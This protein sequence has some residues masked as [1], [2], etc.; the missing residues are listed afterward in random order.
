MLCFSASVS[1][2]SGRKE[3]LFVNVCRL[4]DS[5]CL[6]ELYNALCIVLVGLIIL[7]YVFVN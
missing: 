3:N 1:N 2:I 5:L 6:I 7:W 4:D